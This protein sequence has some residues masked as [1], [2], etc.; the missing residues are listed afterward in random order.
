MHLHIFFHMEDFS[1]FSRCRTSWNFVLK[2]KLDLMRYA[3]KYHK[4]L[5]FLVLVDFEYYISNSF[6]TY[7]N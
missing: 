6:S 5:R 7:L 3:I 2:F 1:S 4:I